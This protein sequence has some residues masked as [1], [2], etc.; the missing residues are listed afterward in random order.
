[1]GIWE[2]NG[3]FSLAS[4]VIGKIITVVL[5]VDGSS[6]GKSYKGSIVVN[7]H[8]VDILVL[9]A[10]ST[11]QI[12]PSP[13]DLTFVFLRHQSNAS[14]ASRRSWQIVKPFDGSSRISRSSSSVFVGSPVKLTNKSNDARAKLY[15]MLKKTKIELPHNMLNEKEGL[16][17][18]SCGQCHIRRLLGE[19]C[20]KLAD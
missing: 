4:R 8:I 7:F 10:T 17:M 1:M 15:Y 14:K 9:D 13:E 19:V 6:E 12:I 3:T 2:S 18:A 16:Q 11:L 5:E 20:D